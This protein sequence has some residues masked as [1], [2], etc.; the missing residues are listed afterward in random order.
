MIDALS[1]R[2]VLI[3]TALVW[4]GIGLIVG[5]IATWLYWEVKTAPMEDAPTRY[6]EELEPFVAYYEKKGPTK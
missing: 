3:L 4:F 1:P 2:A 6:R 5:T